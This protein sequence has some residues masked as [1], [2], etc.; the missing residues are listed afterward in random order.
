[1]KAKVPVG[2]ILAVLEQRDGTATSLE[3][4]TAARDADAAGGT[5]DSA[6]I[7]GA[8]EGAGKSGRFGADRV[9]L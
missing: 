6:H 4:V 1:L 9:V 7:R 5:V 2:A 8:G 3:V